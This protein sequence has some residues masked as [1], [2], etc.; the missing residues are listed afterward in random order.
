MRCCEAWNLW[1]IFFDA[2]SFECIDFQRLSQI[3]ASLTR[4][5][6]EA[7]EAEVSNFP[8]TQTEK[9]TALARCKS[10]QR[11]WLPR[12]LYCLS[13]LVQMKRTIP[14]KTKMNKEE[15][16]VSIGQPFSKHV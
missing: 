6:L 2:S 8:W 12:N 11:V 10:G 3:I 4:E 13:V 15:D 9:D 1:K 14:W 7:C 5:K 16:S